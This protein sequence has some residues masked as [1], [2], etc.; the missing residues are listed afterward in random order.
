METQNLLT[1][2]TMPI[3]SVNDHRESANLTA[4][5]KAC[6]VL[7]DGQPENWPTLEHH[8][9]NEAENQTISWNQEPAHFQLMGTTSNPF[10]FLECHFNIRETTIDTLQDDLKCN[11][12]ID[13][14]KPISQ[15]YRLHSLKTKLKNC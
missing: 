2:K 6:D 13:L 4:M 12:Q 8:L 14:V 15:L 7:F 9:L 11:T 5:T 10:N 1:T 3:K